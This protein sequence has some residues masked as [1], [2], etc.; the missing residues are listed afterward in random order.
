MSDDNTC[1]KEK[2]KNRVIRGLVSKKRG[3]TT[4]IKIQFE[5]SSEKI[6]R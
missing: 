1:Y 6:G 3:I 5:E 4:V 2:K